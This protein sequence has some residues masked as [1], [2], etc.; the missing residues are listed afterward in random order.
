MGT[1]YILHTGFTREHYTGGLG[2]SPTNSKVIMYPFIYVPCMYCF[3][4]PKRQKKL[5][6]KGKIQ[7][8]LPFL[9]LPQ[10]SF[11]ALVTLYLIFLHIHI[12]YIAILCLWFI[13]W[14]FIPISYP[15]CCTLGCLESHSDNTMSKGIFI[16]NKVPDPYVVWKIMLT[17][18][19]LSQR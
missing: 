16:F 2:P 3:L 9:S 4:S 6:G 12:L 1:R 5:S 19:I 11:V 18:I 13:F 8:C 14:F 15:L 10:H 7:A 17:C